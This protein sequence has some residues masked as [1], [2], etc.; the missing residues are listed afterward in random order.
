MSTKA[1]TA[2]APAAN[3]VHSPKLLERVA[4]RFGVDP[5]KMMTTLKATAFKGQVSDEQMMALLIVAEQY[6]LNPWTKEIYAFPDKNNGIVPVVGV[7][8]W[9][10]IINSNPDVESVTFEDGP[11]DEKDIPVWI[12]C[13]IKLRSRPVPLAIKEYFAECSRNTA[14]WTSHP[15][16]MLRHKALIQAGRIALGYVGIYDPDEAERVALATDV[17]PRAAGKPRTAAPRAI[18]QAPAAAEVATITVNQATELRDI[19]DAEGIDPSFVLAK[20][21][22]GSIDE[23]PA[24]RYGEARALLDEVSRD[25]G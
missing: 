18:Q 9:I 8:G 16:R 25:A 23:L 11:P 20:L 4:G 5:S 3:V 7:D 13:T 14:P 15:R 1:V 10:R 6:G 12:E 21:E 2:A 17:T 19:I 22:V 24:A